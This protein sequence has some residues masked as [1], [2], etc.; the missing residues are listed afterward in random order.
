MQVVVFLQA[1]VDLNFVDSFTD[2]LPACIGD[3]EAAAFGR[4]SYEREREM[5]FNMIFSLRQ[6]IDELSATIQ[7]H[8]QAPIPGKTLTD[9]VELYS[10]NGVSPAGIL[11]E[12][13]E[14]RPQSLADTERK[15][16][17]DTLRHNNGRRKDAARLLNISERTL[18]RKIKE[19]GLE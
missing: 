13:G 1:V 16:I 4:H 12:S 19:Y 11:D 9:A 15:L 17:E 2:V 5:L 7:N 3:N 18:Y 6:R 10:D 14:Q 8:Q